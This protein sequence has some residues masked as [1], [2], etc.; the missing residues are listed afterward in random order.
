MP[1][2]QTDLLP[3]VRN[4]ARAL[5]LRDHQV[6]LL[7]KQGERYALPGGAQ[8]TGETLEDALQRECLE[9][10]GTHVDAPR[11]VTVCDVFK[12]KDTV[13]PSRRHL[14]DFIF[15]CLLPADYIAG[16][17]PQPDKR[18][19]D[20]RW[21]DVA[22]LPELTFTPEYLSTW[23]PSL[24]CA[25]EQGSTTVAYAGAFHDDPTA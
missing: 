23:L 19:L 20:V 24:V 5:I 8:D 16:N 17:G 2:R 1:Y 18:Q 25:A 10:I 11:L 21:V 15:L 13:P 14:V 7:L 12:R 3:E 4:T 6:L 9:E 22:A